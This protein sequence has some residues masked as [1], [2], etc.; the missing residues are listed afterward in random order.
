MN[1]KTRS[2]GWCFAVALS[3]LATI[4][5]AQ[6]SAAPA[7]PAPSA[8]TPPPQTPADPPIVPIKLFNGENLYGLKVYFEERNVD[9][10][11]IWKIQDGML[12]ATG[13]GKGYIR[14]EMPYADYKL[15]LEWRWPAQPG[16]SGL[17]LHIVN[18]DTI[19]PKG[20]E[21]QLASGRAGDLSSF[22]DA[23]SK[24][25]IVSRNPTGFSTG[26]LPQMGPSAEKP[27]GQWN[28]LEVIAEGSTLTVSVNGKLV[29]RMTDVV[30]GAGVIALQAEGTAIDFR[31]FVLTPLPR[32]K[33]LHAPM[34]S[35]PAKK[36]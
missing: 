4:A 6:T 26:R 31:N 16:N 5:S 21:C 11:D 29:N 14:T 8:Q 27:V 24:E 28:T 12:R 33:D 15:Q 18:G 7:A 30:P 10:A 25:E 36:Q 35:E 22:V 2:I 34:P 17:M 32:A 3:G 23:R 9:V 20:F 1:G 19:W 13:R